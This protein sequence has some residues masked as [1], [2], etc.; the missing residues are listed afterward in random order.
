M[1]KQHKSVTCSQS[2]MKY[3]KLRSG[4]HA[5]P[6][7]QGHRQGAGTIRPL[8]TVALPWA[9]C[10]VSGMTKYIVK[11][12]YASIWIVGRLKALCAS[13]KDQL[14]VIQKQVLP[15]LYLGASAWWPLLIET[16][17]T[18]HNR[19]LQCE[20][21]IMHSHEYTTII[22]KMPCLWPK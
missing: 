18:D 2:G 1:K 15:V 17:K 7:G 5:V 21:H 12:V 8:S 9:L 6:H 19:L 10:P 22:K 14:N 4:L 3:I 20:I 13:V 11:K 16:D